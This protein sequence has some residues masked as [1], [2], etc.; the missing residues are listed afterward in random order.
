MKLIDG[1][2]QWDFRAL[3]SCGGD[4]GGGGGSGDSQTSN[5]SAK[6][7]FG[8]PAG[9]TAIGSGPGG[10]PHGTGGHSSFGMSSDISGPD[11]SFGGPSSGEVSKGFTDQVAPSSAAN[12]PMTAYTNLANAPVKGAVNA[13]A[14]PTGLMSVMGFGIPG[15]NAPPA[16]TAAPPGNAGFAST[17]GSPGFGNFGGTIGG[18]VSGSAAIGPGNPGTIGTAAQAQSAQSMANAATVGEQM[19]IGQSLSASGVG[20]VGVNSAPSNNVTASTIG[21]GSSVASLGSPNA[22]N[23]IGA[24]GNDAYGG[25]FGTGTPQASSGITGIGTAPGQ[26]GFG[27]SGPVGN[28][29]SGFSLAQSSGNPNAVAT[30]AMAPSSVTAQQANAATGITAPSGQ[31]FGAATTPAV[32]STAQFAGLSTAPPPA[33]TPAVTQAAGGALNVNLDPPAST[34][35]KGVPGVA[36]AIDAIVGMVPG[37]GL[38]NAAS[39][40]LGFGSIGSLMAANPSDAPH[41]DNATTGD[42]GGPSR[43]RSD[44]VKDS[45]T[46]SPSENVRR[47]EEKY[48]GLPMWREAEL[49]RNRPTPY[50]RFVE[51][52]SNYGR[53]L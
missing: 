41:A 37:I 14:V 44:S 19:G 29:S 22:A 34:Q 47:L 18:P 28:I 26:G 13:Q 52:R 32:P 15:M 49:S 35:N 31:N 16:T 51:N 45:V 39:G 12:A 24:I 33:S 8:G 21:P 53:S 1:R 5:T 7:D 20:S 43:D 25:N 50:Q 9:G 10:D 42:D 40:A 2:P 46:S 30:A 6:G 36:T 23:N 27:L 3:I 11:S 48:L 17:F 38:V 4:G